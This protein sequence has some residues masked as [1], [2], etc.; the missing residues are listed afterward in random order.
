V[1]QLTLVKKVTAPGDVEGLLWSSDGTKVAA[2]SDDAGAGI[3]TIVYVPS[4]FASVIT[5]WNAD[6]TVFRTIQRSGPFL[7]T[8]DTFAFVAGNSEIVAPPPVNGND[9]ALSVFDVFGG[10][11]VRDLPGSYPGANRNINGARQLVASPDQKTLAVTFGH[12]RPQPVALYSTDDWSKLAEFPEGPKNLAELPQTLAFSP[13][14]R[15]FAVC[16]IDSKVLIYDVAARALIK[17]IDAFPDVG[18]AGA[19]A[20]SPDSTMIAVASHDT[21]FAHRLADGSSAKGTSEGSI[22]IFGISDGSRRAIYEKPLV[23]RGLAWTASGR[24][25]AFIAGAKSASLHLWQPFASSLS[26]SE[27]DLGGY[28]NSM[29]AS[30][31]GRKLAVGVDR[32]LDIFSVEP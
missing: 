23:V 15:F 1:P 26:E 21:V 3:P 8:F 30:P 16:R 11:T 12:A 13:D 18:G 20:F 19:I 14:G 32:T 10:Q 9:L 2:Y 24:S 25:V 6:G 29:A 7:E 27:I 17:K 28:A 5:I 22:R 4:P 31:D